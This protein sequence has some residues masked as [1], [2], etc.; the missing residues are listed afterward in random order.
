MLGG[1]LNLNFVTCPWCDLGQV[2]DL[3]EPVSSSVSGSRQKLRAHFCFLL[4]PECTHS[5]DQQIPLALFPNIYPKSPLSL[6]H[7]R[8]CPHPSCGRDLSSNTYTALCS[9]SRPPLYYIFHEPRVVF[10]KAQIQSSHF[11]ECRS[12]SVSRCIQHGIQ[13]PRHY[14]KALT[15]VHRL[16]LSP[17][18]PAPADSPPHVRTHQVVSCRSPGLLHI[19][20]PL[21]GD[22][23]TLTASAFSSSDRSL[24]V[25]SSERPPCLKL[26]AIHAHHLIAACCFLFHTCSHISV[27]IFWLFF[28]LCV[29]VFP[30]M[31]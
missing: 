3:S 12:S 9:H 14:F 7:H 6:F 31:M 11:S 30:V 18:S 28:N 15:S 13:T 16:P 27:N 21:P 10:L 1:R 8:H 25:R 19:L 23:Y 22:F 20:F 24:E 2:P 17:S 4:L 29:S 5:I 26:D